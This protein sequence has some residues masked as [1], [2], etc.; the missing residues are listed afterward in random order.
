MGTCAPESSC[1]DWFC[2]SE[3]CDCCRASLF[4]LLLGSQLCSLGSE[5]DVGPG[6]FLPRSV[7]LARSTLLVCLAAKRH[8]HTGFCLSAS[9]GCLL[10]LRR[11]PPQRKPALLLYALAFAPALAPESD[12]QTNPCFSPIA[13]SSS[14]AWLRANIIHQH[15]TSHSH[16]FTHSRLAKITP[17]PMHIL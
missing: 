5:M 9:T 15:H 13:R 11:L 16:H 8:A 1:V 7:T 12:S 2:Y 4:P 10:S 3:K 17:P 14:P 6:G